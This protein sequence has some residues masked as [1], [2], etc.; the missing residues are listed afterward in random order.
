MKRN[1]TK[2]AVLSFFDKTELYDFFRFSPIS[3]LKTKLYCK[4]RTAPPCHHGGG[5][6]WLHDSC[7]VVL[8]ELEVVVVVMVELEVVAVVLVELEMVVVVLVEL[9]VVVVVLVEL[10]V[11]VVV[12]VELEVVVVVIMW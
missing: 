4:N 3:K 12:L 2:H 7:L 10:E 8:V 1:E 6:G 5:R 11:I 9:E